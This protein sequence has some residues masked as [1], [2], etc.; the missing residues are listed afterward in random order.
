[1]KNLKE[2]TELFG[3]TAPEVSAESGLVAGTAIPASEYASRYAYL[4]V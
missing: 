4:L 1:M 2:Y 3:L